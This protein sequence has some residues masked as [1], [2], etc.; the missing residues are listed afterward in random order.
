M[1]AVVQPRS[2][3][4]AFAL[5][6]TITPATAVLATLALL[7]AAYSIVDLSGSAPGA[8]IRAVLVAADMAL[9]CAG[10]LA[11]AFAVGRA[12][13]ARWPSTIAAVAISAAVFLWPYLLL[14]SA[15]SDCTL[16]GG[17]PVR[18]DFCGGR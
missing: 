3:C 6:V 5:I 8:R 16:G 11:L 4:L 10:A 1:L 18:V 2:G 9:A 12:L 15:V 14:T 13:L 17:F 7:Y